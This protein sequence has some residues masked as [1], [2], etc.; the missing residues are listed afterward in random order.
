MWLLTI[1]YIETGEPAFEPYLTFST[2][3]ECENSLTF[4]FLT[5]Y[6]E[7]FDFYCGHREGEEN[8]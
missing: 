6:P 3:S 4:K 5:Q 2:E 1:L 7:G 8:E